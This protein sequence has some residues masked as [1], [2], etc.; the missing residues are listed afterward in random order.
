MLY[1]CTEE[2]LKDYWHDDPVPGFHIACLSSSTIGNNDDNNPGGQQQQEEKKLNLKIFRNGVANDP[3]LCENVGWNWMELKT[4]CLEDN[5]DDEEEEDESKQDGLNILFDPDE[6]Q[7]YAIYSPL[8]QRL[9]D[10]SDTNEYSSIILHV[11]LK[12]GVWLIYEGGQFLWPGVRIG[13]ERHN[14]PL[15]RGH[16]NDDEWDEWE[17]DHEDDEDDDDGKLESRRLEEDQQTVT[18]T[19]LSLK[20]LV[21]SIQGFLS[22][23][24][25][26]HIQTRANDKVEYVGTTNSENANTIA[27]L[28]VEQAVATV[29]E[30][31]Q[32]PTF[33]QGPMVNQAEA[34][35]PQAQAKRSYADVVRNNRST[36]SIELIK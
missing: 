21:V 36:H 4:R 8:G 33:S 12:T 13:F 1:P 15:D 5:D 20:P 28:H 11:L 10:G 24:E 7:P 27:S 26:T 31:P 6:F 19:T 23:D 9:A 35:Y 34:Y 16:S 29:G 17:Y 3:V 14:V 2:F 32:G 25:C 18:I 22:P 30:I